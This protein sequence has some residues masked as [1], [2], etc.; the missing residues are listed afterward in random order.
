MCF[1]M[2]SLIL[3][4]V[5]ETRKGERERDRKRERERERERFSTGVKKLKLKRF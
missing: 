4:K 3:L 1:L 2:Y 5:P